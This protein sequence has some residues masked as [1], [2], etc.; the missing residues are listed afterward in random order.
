M[1]IGWNL[2]CVCIVTA[3]C[4]A[5]VAITALAQG[6]DGTIVSLAFTALG[7]IPAGLITWGV[8]KIQTRNGTKKKE[9]E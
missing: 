6:L 2:A 9:G 4:I 3:I 1:K 5:A 7:A 8:M